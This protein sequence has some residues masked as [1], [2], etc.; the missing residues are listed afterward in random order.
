MWLTVGFCLGHT[1]GRSRGAEHHVEEHS[2][3][4]EAD[5]ALQI[6]TNASGAVVGR[7]VLRYCGRKDEEASVMVGVGVVITT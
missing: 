6:E 1:V 7:L 4:D 2:G 5:E 3:P